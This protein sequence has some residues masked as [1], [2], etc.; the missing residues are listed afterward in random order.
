[1]AEIFIN[2]SRS[3][4]DMEEQAPYGR[5]TGMT[6]RPSAQELAQA[7]TRI[8]EIGVTTRQNLIIDEDRTGVA[9]DAQNQALLETAV[10]QMVKITDLYFT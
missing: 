4:T 5:K 8:R 6:S 1:M 7:V 10:E 9:I 2:H 3:K